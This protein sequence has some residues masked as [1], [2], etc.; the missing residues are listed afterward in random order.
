MENMQK[1]FRVLAAVEQY[2]AVMPTA[3]DGQCAAATANAVC[4]G[5][6][7]APTTVADEDAPVVQFGE[8]EAMLGDTVTLGTHF[9]LKSDSTGRLVPI[10]SGSAQNIVAIPLE[11]G[12]VGDIAHVFV[13]RFASYPQAAFA[14]VPAAIADPGD[15][16][17]VVVTASGHL[18][19]VTT[20]IGGETRTIAAPTFAGEIMSISLKTDG[21]TVVIAV[22]TTVDVAGHNRIT[23]DDAGDSIG[24]IAIASGANLRWR[25][26]FNDGGV[27]ATA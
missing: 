6:T 13:M 21:G 27:L 26:L 10:G 25:V 9:F 15:A 1:T 12:A 24:L 8:T 19:I 17:A 5:I 23:L 7:A 2:R 22:A 14:D 4:Y 18:D 3:V 11:S 20:T 16:G